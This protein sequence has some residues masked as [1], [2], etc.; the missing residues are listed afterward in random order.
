[1]RQVIIENPV[2]NSPFAEPTRHYRFDD[3]GITNEILESRR[4]SS[5]FIPIAKPRKKGRQL[6]LDTEW[7]QDRQQENKDINRI[8][9]R[10]S[11]WRQ[12][13]HPEVT[14]TTGHNILITE[15]ELIGG[16]GDEWP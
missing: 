9:D 2:I 1:M 5:Y 11:R 15:P 4:I 12:G 7:T 10:V 8:R 3:E 14:K 16:A 13:G 6:V